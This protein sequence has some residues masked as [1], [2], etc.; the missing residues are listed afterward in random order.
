MNDR[1]DRIFFV[2]DGSEYWADIPA[3]DLGPT[4]VANLSDEQLAR[5]LGK[6]AGDKPALYQKSRPAA[7][8]EDAD[9]APAPA[10]APPP[11]RAKHAKE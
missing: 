11:K 6:R 10:E 5:A 4:D 8:D 7:R 1:P 2:G 3:R 9:A